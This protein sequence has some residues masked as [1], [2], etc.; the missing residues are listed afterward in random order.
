MTQKTFRIHV[1]EQETPQNFRAEQKTSGFSVAVAEPRLRVAL[2]A[3][4]EIKVLMARVTATL[5]TSTTGTG[6]Q[7]IQ[8]KFNI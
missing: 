6:R 1:A 2:A 8:F 5:H 3:L 4:E 7:C